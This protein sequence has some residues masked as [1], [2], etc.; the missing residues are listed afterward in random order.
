[1]TW[2]RQCQCATAVKELVL[3]GNSTY[4]TPSCFN[5]DTPYT[6]FCKDAKANA[7]NN[8]V[9]KEPHFSQ[10]EEEEDDSSET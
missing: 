6:K 8:E 3:T 10:L 5:C 7:F 1:M 9:P 2:Y 4:G